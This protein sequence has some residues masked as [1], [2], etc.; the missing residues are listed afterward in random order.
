MQ[1][2]VGGALLALREMGVAWTPELLE[3]IIETQQPLVEKV[4]A[5][6]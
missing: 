5:P 2:V 3:R 4:E 1:P 6:G